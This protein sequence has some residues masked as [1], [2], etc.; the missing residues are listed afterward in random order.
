MEVER[1]QDPIRSAV[2]TMVAVSK[3]GLLL[4]THPPTHP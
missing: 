4:P 1:A 2:R 3:V